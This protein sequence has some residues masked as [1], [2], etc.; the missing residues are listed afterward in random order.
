MEDEDPKEYRWETGYEKTWESIKEDDRGFVSDSVAAIERQ[1]NKRK[2]AKKGR[3]GMIRNLYILLDCTENMDS[4]DMRPTRMKCAIKLVDSFIHE[5][6][7]QNPISLLGLIALKSKRAEMV[8]EL[9]G[10]TKKH[11]KSL[12]ML[13]KWPL[14][15]EPSL[16]NG[17]DLALK[18]LKLVPA[19]TSREI[20]VILGSLTTCDPGDLFQTIQE[21]KVHNVQVSFITL[22]AEVYIYKIISSS[23]L[24]YFNAALDENDFQEQLLKHAEPPAIF[25]L[26]SNQHRK[27]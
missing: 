22:S 6:F 19:H 5:F 26:C 17:L 12:D 18:P 7:D 8:T 13:T 21:L 4:Q 2:L 10:N 16:Q 27:C 14:N 25:S 24:G 9:L 20:L 11:T 3:L 1:N 23:T 15:G